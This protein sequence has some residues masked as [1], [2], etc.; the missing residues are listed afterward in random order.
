MRD[1]D[2]VWFPRFGFHLVCSKKL[3]CD[4]EYKQNETTK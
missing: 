2:Y 4:K 3:I 1:I